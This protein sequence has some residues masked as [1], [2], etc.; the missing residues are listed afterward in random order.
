MAVFGRQGR[1]PVDADDAGC[2]KRPFVIR[3]DAQRR[4]V[5]DAVGGVLERYRELPSGPISQT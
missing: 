5:D 1:G 3:D 4:D 2:L